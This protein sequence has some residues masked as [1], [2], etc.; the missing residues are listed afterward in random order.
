MFHR[1]KIEYKDLNSRAQENYNY[2]KL[3]AV[4]ADYGYTTLRLS[5]DWQSAD[6][7]AVHRDGSSIKIQLKG[8]FVLNKDYMG[9]DLWIAFMDR[10]SYNWYL[11]PHDELLSELELD[12][13][14]FKFVD[15]FKNA[16]SYTAATLSS[17][18]SK[19]LGKHKI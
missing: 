16:G 5:D 1:N 7:I 15:W 14:S 11:Y 12:K 9:K 17:S 8:R 10:K 6:C 3:S 2:H 18:L 19:I 4:L 13:E